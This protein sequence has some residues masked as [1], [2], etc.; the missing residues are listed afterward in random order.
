MKLRTPDSDAAAA[1]T[2]APPSGRA[3]GRRYGRGF[4][5]GAL[6]AGLIFFWMVTE[7]S[8]DVG[9]R[10]PFSG[11]FYDVQ[12]HAILDG[13]LSMSPK[14][15]GIEGYSHDGK[16]YMYFGPAPAFLRLPV[17]A[18]TDSLDGHTGVVSMCLAYLVLLAALGRLSWRIRRWAR[19][20]VEVDDWE[21]LLAGVTA[22]AL[23]AGSTVIFL[24]I[25]PYVY[26]EAI[27]WGVALAF[28]A[29]EAILAWIE[30]PRARV[31]VLASVFTLLALLSRLAVGIG[32]AA[33]LALVA[34]AIAVARGW[35][36]ARRATARLGLL[37]EG[38]GWGTAGWLATAVVVPLAVYA[39][40]NYAKFGTLFSVPFDH[41]AVNAI[42]PARKAVLAA[43]GGG[44]VNVRALPTNVW[45]Y[46]R[47]DAVH[48]ES[49]WPWVRLPT[50]RPIVIGNLKYDLLDY[51]SSVTVTMPLLLVMAVAGIVTMLRTRARTSVATP[52]SLSLPVVGAACAAVPSLVFVYITERYMAD[53]LP[54]LVLPA[55]AALHALVGWA[56]SERA[57]RRHV[58]VVTAVL[59]ALVVWGCV[60]NVSIARSYQQGREHITTFLE[61]ST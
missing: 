2:A 14:V 61:P 45:Q 22:F 23:G 27:L 59:L 50:H 9:H 11:N 47:P 19:G 17:A 55:L 18:V 12:A 46:L 43:N 30:R 32:P 52:G 8:F 38:L 34:V 29:F 54:L 1:V 57:S 25:G 49:I 42:L 4:A 37:T 40:F 44:L 60:A 16:S 58:D 21:E 5:I 31:L 56:R 36:R 33:A 28:A 41:Q 39:A 51:T 48:F 26:H 6:L 20:P 3:D 35:P 24:G 53:F 13:H 10:V 15:L 7:G